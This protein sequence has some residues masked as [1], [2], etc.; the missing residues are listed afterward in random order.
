MIVGD[1][2]RVFDVDSK[3]L[4]NVTLMYSSEVKFFHL[5]HSC[6]TT[7]KYKRKDGKFYIYDSD[8][9]W[10]LVDNSAIPDDIRYEDDV[11]IIESI[12]NYD[13]LSKPKLIAHVK[14]LTK[15]KEV[16]NKLIKLYMRRE[17]QVRQFLSK[18]PRDS[19]RPLVTEE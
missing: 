7:E 5:Q 16:D 4:V 1:S 2:A 18:T 8:N 15:R 11:R 9:K 13:S 12:H 19:N 14:K 17:A 6:G 3:E 10:T